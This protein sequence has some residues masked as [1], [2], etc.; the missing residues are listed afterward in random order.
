M[1]PKLSS[2]EILTAAEGAIAGPDCYPP[3]SRTAIHQLHTIEAVRYPNGQF[4]DG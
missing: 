4:R 2:N 1:T 3:G